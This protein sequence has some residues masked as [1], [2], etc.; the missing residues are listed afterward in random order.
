MASY[1]GNLRRI[2]CY[3]HDVL[4]M[5]TTEAEEYLATARKQSARQTSRRQSGRAQLALQRRWIDWIDVVKGAGTLKRL[6]EEAKE[7]KV[8]ATACMHYV[9]YLFFTML[10]PGRGA[11]FATMEIVDQRH[12]PL[13]STRITGNRNACVISRDGQVSLR[14]GDYK[15]VE[16]H[17]EQVTDLSSNEECR[18][19]L[20][21]VM[22]AYINKWRPLRAGCSHSV[23]FFVK[24]GGGPY[25]PNRFSGLVM[26]V[27]KK[28][29]GVNAGINILR[30]SFVT[31]FCGAGSTHRGIATSM[32]HGGVQQEVYN[33]IT[34]EEEMASALSLSSSLCSKYLA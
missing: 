29:T 10:P 2:V 34:T 13:Q 26:R 20:I 19:H 11:E 7:E 23:M 14:L 12:H 25:E 21:P 17:G 9:L 30:K 6:F 4:Q 24:N 3:C 28:V 18:K 33:M 32:R 15:T 16:A 8:K 27:V 31:H 22:L 5:D 1:A